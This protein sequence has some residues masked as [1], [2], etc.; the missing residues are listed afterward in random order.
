M[1]AVTCRRSIIN[2]VDVKTTLNQRTENR[3][4][5]VRVRCCYVVML[6]ITRHKRFEFSTRPIK[7]E[8]GVIGAVSYEIRVRLEN[9][10]NYYG[11]K[12]S[13]YR[14]SRTEDSSAT[15]R[16]CSRGKMPNVSVLTDRCGIRP[17]LAPPPPL[18]AFHCSCTCSRS[19]TTT[20]ISVFCSLQRAAVA[21]C[22]RDFNAIY[23]T[24]E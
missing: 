23:A 22:P 15:V 12:C 13:C 17:P 7:I 19:S 11:G 4:Q 9:S 21:L 10:L 18:S 5:R 8:A 24:A 20:T 1:F 16:S 6:H 2:E 14:S 3:E